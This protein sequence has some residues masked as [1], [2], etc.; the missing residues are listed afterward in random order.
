MAGIKFHH[1]IKGMP[2]QKS[3]RNEDFE[4]GKF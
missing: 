4:F 1:C 3:Q 2:R